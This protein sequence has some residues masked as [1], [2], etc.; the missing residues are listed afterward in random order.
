MAGGGEGGSRLG[1]EVAVVSGHSVR[2]AWSLVTASP[3][4]TDT[5]LQLE[6]VYS[7]LQ[8]RRVHTSQYR[9]RNQ[10]CCS[11]YIVHPIVNPAA[12]FVYLEDL[13]VYTG[14]ELQV[15]CHHCAVQAVTAYQLRLRTAN[16]SK[17]YLQ[18]ETVYFSTAGRYIDYNCH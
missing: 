15:A 1:A 12:E 3:A 13:Q 8:A 4:H 2:V 5:E 11:Y 6:I 16:Y 9:H 17:F 18:S 7:P 14:T 10:R